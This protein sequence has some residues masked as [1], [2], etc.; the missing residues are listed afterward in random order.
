MHR[1]IRRA[2]TTSCATVGALAL[3]TGTALAHE[4]YIGTKITNGPKSANWTHIVVADAVQEFGIV[5]NACPAQL[6][7]GEAALREAGLPL[8]I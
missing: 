6:E 3:F 8:S 7:A 1:M 4:C 2:V 5:P